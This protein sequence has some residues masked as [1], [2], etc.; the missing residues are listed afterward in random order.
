MKAAAR[1]IKT[2]GGGTRGAMVLLRQEMARFAAG[3]R[4]AELTP[5]GWLDPT[6]IALWLREA[7]DPAATPLLDQTP[8]GRNPATA[9]PLAI[10]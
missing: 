2:L 10:E 5:T 7:Y 6:G 8:L 3:L 4:D 1:E 9:G